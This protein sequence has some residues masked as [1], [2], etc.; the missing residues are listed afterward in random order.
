[1][2]Q[3]RRFTALAKDL[4]LVS[5]THLGQDTTLSPA[6]GDPAPDFDPHRHSVHVHKHIHT[7]LKN[8]IKT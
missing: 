6:S 5:N 7:H 1:M 2:D 8:K 3:L 4:S